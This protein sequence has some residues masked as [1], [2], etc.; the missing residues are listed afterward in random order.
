MWVDVS[1]Y[2]PSDQKDTVVMNT[3]LAT[4]TE[5]APIVELIRTRA[6]KSLQQDLLD[7]Y[8]GVPGM[9][10]RPAK[11]PAQPLSSMLEA[12]FRNITL[13]LATSPELQ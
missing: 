4:S 13:S 9:Y 10:S 3:I 2:Q 5:L 7:R 1:T 6:D 8:S 12:L 11:A